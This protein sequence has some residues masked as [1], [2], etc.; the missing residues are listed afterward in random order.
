[1]PFRE[2]T[3]TLDDVWSLFGIPVIG[4]AV[5]TSIERLLDKDVVSLV[6]TQ[7]G[8][9]PQQAVEEL[10]AARGQFVWLEWLRVLIS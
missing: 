2:M 4:R 3:I 5:S 8:V 6:V 9:S 1:M 10:G 7:L